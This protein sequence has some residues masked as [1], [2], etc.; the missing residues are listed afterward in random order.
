MSVSLWPLIPRMRARTR[1]LERVERS[2][3]DCLTIIWPQITS[4]VHSMSANEA[5]GYLHAHAVLH[6]GRHIGPSD[7][8]LQRA[9]TERVVQMLEQG[10][11]Q[12][13][14]VY[15]RRAA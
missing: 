11:Y 12:P 13:R 3:A 15:A 7:Q 9:V 1:W 8:R 14:P 2:A 4:A 10:V 5:Y 6:V